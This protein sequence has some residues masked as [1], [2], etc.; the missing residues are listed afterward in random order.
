MNRLGRNLVRFALLDTSPITIN[1]SS[2]PIIQL[3]SNIFDKFHFINYSSNGKRQN[4]SKMIDQQRNIGD[5]MT[6]IGTERNELSKTASI[7]PASS[8]A[9]LS[10]LDDEKCTSDSGNSNGNSSINSQIYTFALYDAL[11]DICQNNIKYFECD[12]TEIG[13]RFLWS[14]QGIIDHINAI[15]V[16]LSKIVQF[17]HEYD[18]DDKTPANGYRSFVKAVESGVNHSLKVSKYIAQNRSYLLFRKSMYM[19]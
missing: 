11:N 1:R 15:K 13:Q 8:F 4:S 10:S 5:N 17:M 7:S 12:D 9:Q 6:S 18:F 14:F 3:K 19:K 16:K 2:S